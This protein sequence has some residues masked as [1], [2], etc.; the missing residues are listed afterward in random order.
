MH[1]YHL[2][3]SCLCDDSYGDQLPYVAC[4]IKWKNKEGVTTEDYPTED[5]NSNSPYTSDVAENIHADNGDTSS[6]NAPPNVTPEY[7]QSTVYPHCAA[8]Q[9]SENSL[10]DV[11]GSL[12]NIQQL[13]SDGAANR[14]VQD[15]SDA[16]YYSNMPPPLSPWNTYNHDNNYGYGQGNPYGGSYDTYHRDDNSGY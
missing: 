1:E 2:N 13:D 12:P 6:Y 3:A 15:S 9:D 8:Y 14:I 7:H 11:Y 16:F 5:S 4:R 10:Y